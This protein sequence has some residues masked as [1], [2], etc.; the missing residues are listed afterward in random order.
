M[1]DRYEAFRENFI[2]IETHN[3]FVDEEG[4]PAP[5]KMA[6]NQ[7]SDMTE[8]EFVQERLGGA[9]PRRE[10][11]PKKET[12][13]Q[14]A[15]KKLQ[16]IV[17]LDENGSKTM[18]DFPSGA[19]PYFYDPDAPLPDYKNWFE[20]GYVTVPHD[21]GACGACWA[22]STASTLESLAMITGTEPSSE[23]QRYSI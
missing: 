22:F 2:R 7:F 3:A 21:Q 11:K 13:V 16:S 20:E 12:L 23:L 10:R 6:I 19:M 8:A 4:R 17:P 9:M 18:P 5:F 15:Q 1:Q 14:K